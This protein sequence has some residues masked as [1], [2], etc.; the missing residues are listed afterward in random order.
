M[1]T[2]IKKYQKDTP[3]ILVELKS[4]RRV[5]LWLKSQYFGFGHLL[6]K[7]ETEWLV[8]EIGDFLTNRIDAAGTP[9]VGALTKE[10]L[11]KED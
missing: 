9:L 10:E 8:G 7:Q 2:K 4:K 5:W 1:V 11:A 3:F 6:G